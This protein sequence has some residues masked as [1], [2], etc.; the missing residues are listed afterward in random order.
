MSFFS[1]VANGQQQKTLNLMPVP[2]TLNLKGVDFLLSPDFTIGIYTKKADTILVKAANRFYQTLSRKTG[3]AFLQEYI[4]FRDAGKAATL[5]IYVDQTIAPSIG[6]DESYSLTV[7]TSEILLKAPTTAGALHGLQTLIQLVEKKGS[8]YSVPHVVINDAPRFQWRGLML[9]VSR[10]FLPLDVL[11]RNIDAMAA[12]KMNVLHLHLTDDQ[13]FRIESKLFPELHSKGS[14]GDYF[15]QSQMKDLIQYAMERGIEI[16]PEF[17]MPG[18]SKSWFDGHPE[19][20]SAPGPYEPGSPFSMNDVKDADAENLMQHFMS[21]PLPTMNP[22]KESTYTF[23]NKFFAEMAALFPSKYVHIGADENNGVAWKQNPEIV[24]F[25]K[26]NNLPDPHSLQAYFVKRV[27]KILEKNN[28]QTIGWEE[29]FS[30]DLP[31]N[32]TVQIWQTPAYI[33]KALNNG[34][35]MLMSM[36]FYTD[37]FMPAYIHYNNP[38]MPAENTTLEKALKGGEAAQWT[39]IADKYNIETRVWPRAAAIAER[40]WSP[41]VVNDVDDMYRRLFAISTQLDAA[42]LQHEIAYD[43]ALRQYTTGDE[44]NGLKTLTD[45]LEPIKGYKKLFSM[46]FKPGKLMNQTAP[47]RD[48]S[49]IIPVDAETK[50]IFRMAVQSYLLQKDAASEKIINHYLQ[51]WKNNDEALAG[52]WKN[53]TALNEVREHSKQL[54]LIADIGIQ[55]MQQIK[56]GSKAPEEWINKSM[57]VLKTASAVYGETTIAIISEIESLVKQQLVSLPASYSIY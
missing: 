45:V 11:Q 9:D 23:L 17:D 56:S 8:G 42:G 5:K 41:A 7:S 15:T 49:D 38:V 31:K 29:L 36:G 57:E 50:W 40:L 44:L 12:V 1:V 53:S 16:V 19:L 54:A 28:K 14:N 30:T 55:A 18:H 48:V 13:G 39:E 10:H 51:R 20:A 34:N 22:A 37:L 24:T 3:M 4:K 6:V 2:K 46:M 25:M 35:P 32:V 21:Q 52:I 43:R 26:K 33:E 47:L 27:E